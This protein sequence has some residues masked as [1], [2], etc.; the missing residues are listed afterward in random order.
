[1]RKL[2][3]A[4]RTTQLTS[5]SREARQKADSIN[6]NDLRSFLTFIASDALMG[7]DTPSQGL[8]TAA[9]FIAFNLR[10]FGA[11]PGGDEGTFFQK[12]PLTRNNVI[13]DKCVFSVGEK[14]LKYGDDF[15]A[16]GRISGSGRGDL[17][18]V[19]HGYKIPSKNI[20][21]YSGVDVRGKI[22]VVNGASLPKGVAFADLQNGRAGEDWFD[23]FNY[24]LKNGAEGIIQIAGPGRWNGAQ[25]ALTFNGGYRMPRTERMAPVPPVEGIPTL[26]INTEAASVLFDGSRIGLETV[27]AHARTG[28]TTLPVT[29]VQS[30]KVAVAYGMETRY[31]QN[32]VAIFEGSDPKLKSEYVA[33]GAH[34]DH[35]GTTTRPNKEGDMIFNGADDD[36]SGTVGLLAMAQAFSGGA[37]PKRS[38]LFVWHAGE[39]QGL[40]GSDYFTT[41]PT[42]GIK[43]IVAQLNIDMIGRSK[44]ANDGNPRNA[45]LSRGDEIFVIGS[46]MMSTEFGQ[47]VERVNQSYKKIQYDFRYDDPKDP[48]RFF[49]R[50]DHYNYAR[51]GIPI[52]FWFD[53]E[54]QDY[55]GL[56]DEVSKIDFHKLCMIAQ[57]VFLTAWEVAN[58]PKAPVVDK[59]PAGVNF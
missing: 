59:K 9:E 41:K 45:N 46:K 48:N 54:H 25:K 17:V 28:E 39:E 31:T 7:R 3:E 42:V 57:T 58:M 27:L 23:A 32:V 15:L 19:G 53:G 52:A 49:Y 11:R 5:V 55:H 51:K 44:L 1:M 24:A 8:D 34:Y 29:L 37:R 33:V 13:A 16:A 38:I 2:F 18:Y 50:S 36:G 14:V 21:A 47:L 56:G 40:W 20:D 4:P 30:A 6:E 10:R 22:L 43:Q 12:I 26:L 35:V